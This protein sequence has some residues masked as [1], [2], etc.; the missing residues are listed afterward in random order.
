LNMVFHNRESCKKLEHEI[1]E[2]ATK[3]SPRA[4]SLEEIESEIARH[5]PKP[6][7]YELFHHVYELVDKG[8]LELSTESAS[9][10]QT[11]VFR[12]CSSSV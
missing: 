10:R 6:S 7:F 1:L 4:L 11:N 8:N 12:A 2:V 5:N 9:K 3:S